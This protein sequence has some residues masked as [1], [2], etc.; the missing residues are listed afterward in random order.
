MQGALIVSREEQ[1]TTT[2]EDILLHSSFRL[3]NTILLSAVFACMSLTASR[4]DQQ[5]R[6]L[7]LNFQADSK[8]VAEMDRPANQKGD[9][10][11]HAIVDGALLTTDD[12]MKALLPED[13]PVGKSL[14]RNARLFVVIT[15]A[16]GSIGVQNELAFC[17][18]LDLFSVAGD[19]YPE[20]ASCDG[21]K[22]EYS[23]DDGG[24][25]IKHGTTPVKIL[26]LEAGTYSLNNVPFLVKG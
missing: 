23:T 18:E 16:D 14:F 3:A 5:S 8:T 12:L 4:A 15:S 11:A 1:A 26:G 24:V 25:S 19:L 17:K 2:K 13:S 9:E 10:D 21:I 20:K 22:Y 6:T 7:E